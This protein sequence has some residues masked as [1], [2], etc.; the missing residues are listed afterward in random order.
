MP[1]PT[2]YRLI[3]VVDMERFGD[4]AR[5]DLHQA[6]VR[7]GLYDAMT[8]ACAESGIDLRTCVVEDRGDGA[9]LLFPP[10]VPG[11]LVLDRLPHR[12]SVALRRHNGVHSPEASIKLRYAV[13]AGVVHEDPYGYS[14]TE[15]NAA[16]RLVEA[17]RLKAA[18]AES[19][20]VLAMVVSDHVYRTVI[21]HDPGLAPGAYQE[22]PVSVKET[23]TTA[24]LRRF[25]DSPPKRPAPRPQGVDDLFDLVNALLE[26]PEVRQ[27]SS[28]R[29]L[30]DLLRRDIAVAVPNHH[31]DRMHVIAMVRTCLAFDNGIAELVATVRKFAGDS[32]PVRRVEAITRLWS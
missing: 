27:E 7:G 13:H 17:P 9:M 22:I 24:W 3:L 25:D 1:A 4:P 14:G 31:G 2:Q 32:E 10:D 28:R 12:W 19:S 23:N 18:L 21:R 15:L 5:T 30:L 16:F 20:G 26:V 11:E 6:E 8:A 29:L